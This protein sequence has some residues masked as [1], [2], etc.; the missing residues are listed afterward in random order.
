MKLM[1]RL[2]KSNILLVV[3]FAKKYG[4]FMKLFLE[5]GEKLPFK[6]LLGETLSAT[7]DEKLS[8]YL[9]QI[10][11]K[12]SRTRV[13]ITSLYKKFQLEGEIGVRSKAKC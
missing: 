11:L 6:P 2:S 9:E 10:S 5:A 4:N 1:I 7:N 12:P 8:I 3:S 13:L